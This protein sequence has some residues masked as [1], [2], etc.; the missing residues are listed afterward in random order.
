M[1]LAGGVPGVA[2]A[3]FELPTTTDGAPVA[4]PKR[5]EY[6]YAFGS[7]SDVVYRTDRDLDTALHDD[8]L[9]LLPNANG[10]V[11]YRPTDWL[12][13]TLELAFEREIPVVEEDFVRLPTGE[14]VPAPN[15]HFSLV[16]DQA[17]LTLHG[18]T[19]PF[20][21]TAGRRKF[22]D[23]RHW[24]YDTSIDMAMVGYRDALF[25]AFVA[26][27]REV[28]VGL[29][30][31]QRQQPDRINTLIVSGDYR[32]IE[33]IKI[34]AYSILRDDRRGT[35]GEPLLFGLRSA[36]LVGERFS[37]WSELAHVTGT[38]EEIRDL[39]G[40][41]VDLGGTYRFP[42]LPFY[43]NVTL[44]FAWGSGDKNPNDG[45]NRAFRQSGLQ[46]N[47]T[48]FGGVADFK[49]YGE[50]LDPELSN[51]LILTAGVGA[52]P[53]PDVTAD[54][55]Y[56]RYWL[57]ERSD[58]LRNSALTAPMNN[59]STDVGHGLDV[60]VG[61]R[62][63]LGIRSFGIDLRAGWFFPGDAFRINK[64]DDEDVIMHAPD[65]ASAIVLKFWL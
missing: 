64:G 33:G 62:N 54:L 36:G 53:A 43:P 52:R 38:D 8:T 1:L 37:Y 4:L 20:A 51:L 5:L 7:E 60:V 65:A 47:E 11:T 46:S 29:D 48:R 44:G 25:D 27:G 17:F 57:D 40:Y 16:V 30:L 12:E 61:F 58:E 18:V 41:A 2:L 21:L 35:E 59:S 6:Q 24:L 63:V 9:T 39:R 14:V 15:R 22:E 49:V 31:L 19:D 45:T 10:Y 32:G 34:G 3:Q 23:S 13:G 26:A 50:A 55:I 28:V 56:H 42:D